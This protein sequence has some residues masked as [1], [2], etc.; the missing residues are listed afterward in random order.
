MALTII[1]FPFTV[2]PS[3]TSIK[4]L[5]VFSIGLTSIKRGVVL[6]F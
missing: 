3:T 2:L 6:L 4:A 1:S 5:T